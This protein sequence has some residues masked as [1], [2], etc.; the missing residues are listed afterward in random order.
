MPNK[1][2]RPIL[3]QVGPAQ[4]KDLYLDV[5]QGPHPESRQ[6]ACPDESEDE[7]DQDDTAMAGGL[8]DNGGK[9]GTPQIRRNG[10]NNTLLDTPSSLA[11]VQAV[12][13][14][15]PSTVP[16]VQVS[17]S[18]R[19]W[20]DQLLDQPCIFGLK[21]KIKKAKA[22]I[23]E[24]KSLEADYSSFGVV[25][26]EEITP[27]KMLHDAQPDYPFAIEVESSPSPLPLSEQ[28]RAEQIRNVK[29]RI[30][31]LKGGLPTPYYSFFGVEVRGFA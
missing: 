31:E 21:E 23:A 18:S 27:K 14:P 17:F 3:Q 22:C 26:V 6:G 16:R 8:G 28:D 4:P 15:R 12:P 13:T 5:C 25:D 7:D 20:E 11:A 30:A 19:S 29:A 1:S 9:D 10:T 2:E 24:A